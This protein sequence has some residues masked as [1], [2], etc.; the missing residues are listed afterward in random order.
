MNAKNRFFAT[1]LALGLN[2]YLNL[3]PSVEFGP[4]VGCGKPAKNRH[5]FKCQQKSPIAWEA[6][7]EDSSRLRGRIN[8]ELVVVSRDRGGYT[9]WFRGEDVMGGVGTFERAKE[10]ILQNLTTL[11]K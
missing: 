8:G 4:C 6:A 11:F 5:C 1:A 10:R 3:K 7:T 9:V 2:P